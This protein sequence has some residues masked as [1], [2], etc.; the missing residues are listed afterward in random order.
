MAATDKTLVFYKRPTRGG[1]V[2][3]RKLA[4][5]SLKQ[6]TK[7]ILGVSQEDRVC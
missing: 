2:N 4:Q 6:T 7:H 1:Y 3:N 5:F